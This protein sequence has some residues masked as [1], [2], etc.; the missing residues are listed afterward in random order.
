M[1]TASLK[2]AIT[3]PIATTTYIS[4][5]YHVVFGK[6]CRKSHT[7][8]NNTGPLR[9]R[10]QAAQDDLTALVHNDSRIFVESGKHVFDTNQSVNSDRKTN[11][12]CLIIIGAEPQR[13]NSAGPHEKQKYDDA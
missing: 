2:P 11:G 3:R 8:P 12:K 5:P 9:T 4:R 6:G 10:D 1:L 7:P 13:H